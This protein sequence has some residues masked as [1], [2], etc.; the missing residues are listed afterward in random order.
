MDEAPIES[1]MDRIKADGRSS[2]TGIHWKSFHDLLCR[3][4]VRLGAKRPPVPLILAASGEAS[5]SKHQRLG[6]QLRWAQANGV[7]AEALEF[8]HQLQ[9]DHWN[10]VA[11]A[12]WYRSGYWQPPTL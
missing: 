6:E 3:Q 1:F 8:L 4:A 2:P 5:S 7:L 9:P 12:D 11:T 10:Q